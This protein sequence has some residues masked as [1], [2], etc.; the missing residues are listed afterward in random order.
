VDTGRTLA[1]RTVVRWLGAAD[2]PPV[3]VL[4]GS[5]GT[6][7]STAAAWWL[8]EVGG[9]LERATAIATAWDSSTVTA[10]ERRE[11]ACSTRCLV[12]DDV[13]TEPVRYR[14]AMAE[15]LREL[16]E[17]RQSLR[18]L[19]TTNLTRSQFAARYPDGRLDSRL[20]RAAWVKCVGE[21]LRRER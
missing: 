9:R 12:L 4:A 2:A 18:T 8:A 17:A 20:S 11:S 16:M 19:V 6:G 7:K 3:L 5:T 1:M 21:D 15:A 14:G 10:Q 13:G